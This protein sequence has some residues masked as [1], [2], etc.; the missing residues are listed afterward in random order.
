MRLNQNTLMSGILTS[1][2]SREITISLH[3]LSPCVPLGGWLALGHINSIPKHKPVLDTAQSAQVL[4]IYRHPSQLLEPHFSGRFACPGEGRLK[5]SDAHR[6]PQH[7]LSP[8]PLQCSLSR[9]LQWGSPDSAPEGAATL[10]ARSSCLMLS[11]FS[12]LYT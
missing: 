10:Q 3:L 1:A 12:H 5:N 4:F 8:C 6:H 9:T 7:L 2:Q 11:P